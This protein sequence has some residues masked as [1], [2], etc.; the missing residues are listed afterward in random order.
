[1]RRM[2]DSYM[3]MSAVCGRINRMSDTERSDAVH[4]ECDG[5]LRY[6]D[7]STGSYVDDNCGCGCHAEKREWYLSDF[8]I[9]FTLLH[10]DAD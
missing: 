10:G 2:Q 1:M 7:P 3:P 4:G 5:S 9:E 6:I 8:G